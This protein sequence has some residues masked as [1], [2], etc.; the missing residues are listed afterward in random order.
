VF[1]TNFSNMR[2]PYS[3]RLNL[4]VRPL[5]TSSF[6]AADNAAT[7][8][9]PSGLA[10]ADL[11]AVRQD[12][13]RP[14]DVAE[15]L[16]RDRRATDDTLRLER[17][18]ADQVC[19]AAIG[20]EADGKPAAIRREFD[21]QESQIDAPERLS[22]VVETLAE[23]ADSL[24]DAAD[25]LARAA[26]KLHGIG[27]SGAVE[28][29]H[30]VS[31]ALDEVTGESQAT[32]VVMPMSTSDAAEPIV[33]EQLA[34]VADRLGVVAASLAEERAQADDTVREE[35]ARLDNMLLDDPNVTDERL[36]EECGEWHQLLEEERRKTDVTLERE[37]ADTDQAVVETFE[38][39]RQEQQGHDL[40]RTMVVTRDQFLAIVSHDLRTPLSIV[41]VNAAIISEQLPGD[42]S[43][44]LARAIDRLQRA[45]HQMDRMLADLLDATRF[46]HGQFRLSPTT[47]DIVGVLTDA[48]AQ[49]EELARSYG[50]TLRL[51]TPA[52]PVEVRF[53][54]DR[55]VQVLSNLVRN[56]L[57]FTATGGE[58]TLRVV[59]QVHACR[60]DVSDTGSGI[61]ASD[62]D[63]IFHRFQQT[64]VS[65]AG[66]L[67][68]GL[69]ISRAIVEAHGGRI[70]VD[71]E[72]GKGSTFSFTLPA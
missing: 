1:D 20:E 55:I 47:A 72:P 13:W 40:T 54:H 45:A 31:R 66:G 64:A 67:G 18:R 30:G 14:E 26:D 63:R 22:T 32:Q 5:M 43:P 7:H 2:L 58:I 21:A 42:A 37:R 28:T 33:A 60:I 50:V 62:L 61:S 27:E 44:E 4:Y 6:R 51:E 25:G 41:A 59:P 24:S 15:K 65:P 69:Y 11:P 52:K 39:L 35:R 23:A 16:E 17:E 71:S 70:W 9:P 36:S 56:A 29:L 19:A 48:A 8:A 53:D 12:E 10:F 46:E 3:S 34:E 38:L 68:L 49:F 57:Q